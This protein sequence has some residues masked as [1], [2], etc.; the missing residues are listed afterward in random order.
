[1]AVSYVALFRG[2]EGGG[3]RRVDPIELG[4]LLEELGYHEVRLV[5]GTA[6]ALIA[7]PAL[8]PAD[9]AAGIDEAFAAR[10]GFPPHTI[11]LTAAELAGMVEENPLLDV[12]T[13][14]ARLHVAVL[15][16]PG[17]RKLL[18]PL[19]A[20]GWAP[21]DLAVGDRAAYLWCPGGLI[22]SRLASALQA[23]LANAVAIRS[24]KTMLQLSAGA[25]GAPVDGRSA[26]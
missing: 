19:L 15:A 13:D 16:D 18:R 10:F 12:A 25:A 24:W 9:A 17:D 23:A 14:A 26:R 21:E 8:A 11:V 4:A 2:L 6:S 22:A 3:A 5:A 20:R 7:A 1:M